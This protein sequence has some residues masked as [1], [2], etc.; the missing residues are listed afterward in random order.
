MANTPRP[1]TWYTRHSDPPWGVVCADCATLASGLDKLVALETADQHAWDVHQVRQPVPS[2]RRHD[3]NARVEA[4]RKSVRPSSDYGSS[5]ELFLR[6]QVLQ[7]LA[8]IDHDQERLRLAEFVCRAAEG[9][10]SCAV[11]WEPL[12]PG[13]IREM[14]SALAAWRF[15]RA[16]A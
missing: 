5:E 1:Q 9:I 7:L 8:V 11:A 15:A 3:L 14:A 12:T 10:E 6:G 2:T 13:D 4:I 16:N